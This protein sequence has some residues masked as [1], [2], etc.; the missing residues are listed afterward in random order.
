VESD[1]IFVDSILVG[2]G[3]LADDLGLGGRVCEGIA[4]A[5]RRRDLRRASIPWESVSEVAEH[6]LTVVSQG[7]AL[8]TPRAPSDHSVRLRVARRMPLRTA[9]GTRLHLVDLRLSDPESAT[10]IRVTGL[11]VRRRHRFSWPVSL[12]PRPRGP[13]R[14][15]RLVP[16]PDV[17]VTPS[18]L[19][20]ERPYDQLEPL[21]AS[22]VMPPPK[23]VPRADA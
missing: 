14:D 9:D 12:R 21:T 6:A 8:T 5:V 4:R 17:K 3:V 15:W 10:R 19:V 7:A 13:A 1:G 22:D 2:G 20:L 16:T 11:I 23:R 18:E